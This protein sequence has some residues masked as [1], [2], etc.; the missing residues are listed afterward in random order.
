MIAPTIVQS[1]VPVDHV[2]FYAG[3][4][5]EDLAVFF[6]ATGF[7]LTPLGR[8]DSG[9]VNRLAILDGQY[10][11]LMGFESGT[12]VTVRP[13]LR[14]LAPD[15]NGIVAADRPELHRDFREGRF[16]DPVSLTRPVMIAGAERVARFSITALRDAVPDVRVFLCRHHTPELVWQDHWKQ[17]PNGAIDLKQVSIATRHPLLLHK[18]L[19]TAFDFAGDEKAGMPV[20]DAARTRIEVL[21]SDLRSTLTVRTSNL[22]SVL[23]RARRHNLHHAILKEAGLM[24]HLPA[25]YKADLIF[26][27]SK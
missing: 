1:N 2:V 20:C 9:S 6:Q 13:E 3:D 7:N 10:I 22:A 15:L 25:P 26:T 23:E 14:A 17:H 8:H 11:E 5:L 19:Q 16:K 27:T 24:I 18:A 21:A 12:P 4:G